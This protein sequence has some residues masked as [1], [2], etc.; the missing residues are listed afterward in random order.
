MYCTVMHCLFYCFFSVLIAQGNSCCE[1][2]GSGFHSPVAPAGTPAAQQQSADPLVGQ[3]G[4]V[5]DFL[6]SLVSSFVP[7]KSDIPFIKQASAQLHAQQ[8]IIKVCF[9]SETVWF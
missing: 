5:R 2:G 9:I 1:S 8:L 4:S 3:Q 7:V 6:C